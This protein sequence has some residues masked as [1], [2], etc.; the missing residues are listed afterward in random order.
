MVSLG[1]EAKRVIAASKVLQPS[2]LLFP[3]PT[4]LPMSDATMS[5]PMERDGLC[6]RPRGFR[7]TFRTWAKEVADTPFEVAEAVL[8][9]DR[10]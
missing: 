7:A 6:Y 8:G 5:R 1:K 3:S 4:G 9:R 2:K 10:R